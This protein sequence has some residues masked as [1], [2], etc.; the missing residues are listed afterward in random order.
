MILREKHSTLFFLTMTKNTVNYIQQIYKDSEGE[1]KLIKATQVASELLLER[2]IT[3]SDLELRMLI[4]S[5]V[6]GLNQGLTTQTIKKE[7]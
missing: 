6:Y 7:V 4:E 5:A 1:L 3:L 2:G